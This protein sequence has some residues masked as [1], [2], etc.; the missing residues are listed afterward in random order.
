[1]PQLSIQRESE[2]LKLRRDEV[3][4]SAYTDV[5]EE[6]K[7]EAMAALENFGQK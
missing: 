2:L 1:M 6:R 7:C 4:W 5:I 3:I